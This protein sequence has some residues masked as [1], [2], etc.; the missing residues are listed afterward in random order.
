MPNVTYLL[1]N[2]TK[3]NFGKIWLSTM[4]GPIFPIKHCGVAQTKILIILNLGKQRLALD[5]Y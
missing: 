4:D 3:V 5:P 1:I 2:S